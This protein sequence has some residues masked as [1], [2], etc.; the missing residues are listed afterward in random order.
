MDSIK[1]IHSILRW[2]LL[3]SALYAIVQAYL[4]MNKKSEFSKSDNL[5]GIIFVSLV[6]VQILLGLVLYFT[7]GLGFKNI[8]ALGMGEVMKD[9]YFRF[10]AVE[11]IAGM[12]IALVLVHI[13]RAKCKSAIND[14]AKHK[15][16]FVWYLIGLI[17]MLASIPWPF[18]KGFEA[19]GWV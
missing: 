13:G 8:S 6:D 17:I 18:R 11:H 12:L 14:Y 2:L 9:G 3:L 15:T 16:A 10:F 4:G 1:H 19:L 7:S 5:A